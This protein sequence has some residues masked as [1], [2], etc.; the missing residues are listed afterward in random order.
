M[1]FVGSWTLRVV[2]GVGVAL[3]LV[4]AVVATGSLARV[5]AQEEPTPVLFGDV[6]TVDE[7][8]AALTDSGFGPLALQ[9][10][11]VI[12]PWIP[13][14]SAGILVLEG[15]QVEVYQLTA[16][17]AEEAIGNLTGDDAAFQPPANATVWRGLEFVL[18]LQDAP[19]QSAVE[20]LISSIVGPPALLT[21]A[22][23]LPLP[24]P[25]PDAGADGDAADQPDAAVAD[26]P[27]AL[28]ASGSGGLG[29]TDADGTLVWWIVAGVGLAVVAGLGTMRLRP[30][31]RRPTRTRR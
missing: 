31:Q 17:E 29:S 11:G 28:P 13:V 23:P 24:L 2:A 5:E 18:I 30:G 9:E 4:A 26:P 1:F 6:N 19:N 14:P 21:I 27:A 10:I 25:E 8:F 22:G 15:A 16:A 20:Q 7:F 12:Q 3:A